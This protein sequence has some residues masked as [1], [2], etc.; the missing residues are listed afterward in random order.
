MYVM[1]LNRTLKNAYTVNFMLGVFYNGKIPKYWSSTI[2]TG[3]LGGE[4]VKDY[5]EYFHYKQRTHYND[6]ERWTPNLYISNG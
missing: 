3:K 5:K 4:K 1:P 6:K 2:G